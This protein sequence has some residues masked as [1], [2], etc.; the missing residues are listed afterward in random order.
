[1]SDINNYVSVAEYAAIHNVSHIT[2][3]KRCRRGSFSSARKIGRNW[4]LDKNEPFIDRRTTSGKYRG[5][6]TK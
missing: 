1:M 3:Q 2:I 4:I 5:K 6:N